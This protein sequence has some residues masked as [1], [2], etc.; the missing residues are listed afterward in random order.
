MAKGEG[1]YI[2]VDKF[3]F[4]D[5]PEKYR[6]TERT[7]YFFGVFLLISIILSVFNLPFSKMMSGST[8][9]SIDLGYPM[10]MFSL[11]VEDP[12][13]MPLRFGGLIVNLFLCFLLGFGCEVLINVSSDKFRK[14]FSEEAKAVP[15]VY[16]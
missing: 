1:E 9:F 10:T 12:S 2:K 15:S 3:S 6:P 5:I 11:S 14:T 16:K 4:E 7:F 8:D 13:L